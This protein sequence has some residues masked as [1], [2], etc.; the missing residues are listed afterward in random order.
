M[1]RVLLV[2]VALVLTAC[3]PTRAERDA[4]HNERQRERVGRWDAERKAAEEAANREEIGPIPD[5][6]RRAEWEAWIKSELID[7]GSATITWQE[8][9]RGIYRDH[10]E[11]RGAWLTKAIVNAKNRHGGYVG[12]KTWSFYFSRGYTLAKRAPEGW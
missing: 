8:P 7:P 1:L 11:T 9:E 5:L 4:A 2:L 6:A 12:S 3:G 10:R